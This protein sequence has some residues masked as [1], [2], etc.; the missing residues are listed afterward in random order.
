[1]DGFTNGASKHVQTV[2]ALLKLAVGAFTLTVSATAAIAIWTFTVAA[3]N[4]RQDQS[5]IVATQAIAE[6]NNTMRGV[7]AEQQAMRRDVEHLREREQ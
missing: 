6:M 4:D 1:M 2:I 5:L 3:T 7:V